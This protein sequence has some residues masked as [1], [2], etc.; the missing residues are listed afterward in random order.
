MHPYGTQS[1]CHPQMVKSFPF[2]PYPHTF[3]LMQFRIDIIKGRLPLQRNSMRLNIG[4]Y[5]IMCVGCTNKALQPCH[6]R[7]KEA[8]NCLGMQLFISITNQSKIN[9]MDGGAVS[10]LGG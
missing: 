2:R 4:K 7:C 6:V 1:A 9:I 5:F 8:P 3:L 10:I